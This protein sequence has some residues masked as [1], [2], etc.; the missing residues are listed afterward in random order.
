MYLKLSGGFCDDVDFI[1]CTPTITMGQRNGT[2]EPK[3][4][5][6]IESSCHIKSASALSD[7]GTHL[8]IDAQ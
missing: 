3:D 7:A 1:V 5:F 2:E 4:I 6:T 8:R